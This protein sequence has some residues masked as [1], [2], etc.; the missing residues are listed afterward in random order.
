MQLIRIFRKRIFFLINYKQFLCT[1]NAAFI[2]L[3]LLYF[4][5]LSRLKFYDLLSLF[6]FIIIIHH[7]YNVPYFLFL[8]CKYKQLTLLSN[9]L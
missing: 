1:Y 9:I 5:V 7:I 4:L 3:H 6:S 8:I 2:G